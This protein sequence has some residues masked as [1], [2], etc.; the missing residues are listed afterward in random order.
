ML[1]IYIPYVLIR[2]FEEVGKLFNLTRYLPLLQDAR[3][4]FQSLYLAV[5]LIDLYNI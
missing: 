2:V 3:Q 1:N 4:L 5:N